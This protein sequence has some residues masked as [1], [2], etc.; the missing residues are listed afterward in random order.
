METLSLRA[1]ICCHGEAIAAFSDKLAVVT[2]GRK[3]KL[4]DRYWKRTIHQGLVDWLVNFNYSSFLFI[5]ICLCIIT[6][7]VF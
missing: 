4:Q 3:E 5:D 1:G 2:V 7:M 6:I